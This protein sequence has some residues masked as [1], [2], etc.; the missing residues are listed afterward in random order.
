MSQSTQDALIS[1]QALL[2]YI[3]LS[4]INTFVFSS[5][6]YNWSCDQSN[7][8]TLFHLT[9]LLLLIVMISF[10]LSILSIL[11]LIY[12]DWIGKIML[13]VDNDFVVK[14]SGLL[15][16]RPSL[17]SRLGF[18]RFRDFFLLLCFNHWCSSDFKILWWEHWAFLAFLGFPQNLLIFK[19]LF[20]VKIIDYIW[21]Y[22]IA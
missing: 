13:L 2:V 6:L 1:Y 8:I 12:F 11:I 16:L 3:F 10:N 14:M 20:L 5:F 22:N 17:D 19:V 9:V 21:I 18:K 7:F 4:N 15:Y